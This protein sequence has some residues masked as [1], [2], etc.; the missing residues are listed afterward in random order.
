MTKM[1][2]TRILLIGDQAPD[3][4]G[5]KTIEIVEQRAVEFPIV[6]TWCYHIL[7][8]L[9]V[10]AAEKHLV[11]VFQDLPP[12]VA[13]AMTNVRETK[14]PICETGVQITSPGK[15]QSFTFQGSNASLDDTVKAL[16]FAGA[17]VAVD[18]VMITVT[19][20]PPQHEHIE[21]W[22]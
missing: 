22:W 18:G 21:W 2:T 15:P 16:R 3:F 10:E 14:L 8:N 6:G 7:V 11:L 19:V 20:R 9:M 5:N 1:N 12:Q 4:G 17:E 13:V